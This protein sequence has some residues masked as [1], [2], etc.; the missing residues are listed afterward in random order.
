MVSSVESSSEGTSSVSGLST[1]APCAATLFLRP[2]IRPSPST[3]P[4]FTLLPLW[5]TQLGLLLCAALAAALGAA[6][7][8]LVPPGENVPES[9][10]EV[11]RR[12]PNA[13]ANEYD[14][15]LSL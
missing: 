8:P 5:L 14:S 12:E 3:S 1:G 4:E 7:R 15:S 11:L 10:T 6:L 2:T 13:S 9:A